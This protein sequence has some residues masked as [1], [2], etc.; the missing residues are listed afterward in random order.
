MDK[1][2]SAALASYGMLFVC[3]KLAEMRLLLWG[4]GGGGGE[5]VCFL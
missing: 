4:G 1:F 2:G 5:Y 3:G